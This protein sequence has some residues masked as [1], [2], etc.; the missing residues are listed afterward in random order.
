GSGAFLVSA[1]RYLAS[2]AE[3]ALVRDGDWH[4][5]DVT[6][7]DRIT[8]RRDVGQRCLFGADL[9]PMAVQLGRLSLWLAT[10]SGERPLTFLDHHLVSGDSLV[11]AALNDVS[12]QPPGRRRGV[13]RSALPLFP[14]AGIDE[15]LQDVVAP[16]EQ[17]AAERDGRG[18]VVRRKETLLAALHTDGGGLS[19]WKAVLGLWCACWFWDEG[20]PP[21][22]AL[23]RE[24]ADALLGGKPTLP[25]EASRPWLERA[26]A[27]ARERRFL[28]WTLEFPEVFYDSAGRRQLDA[29]FDAVLGNP[30]WDMVRRDRGSA[31]ERA[32]RRADAQQLVEFAHGSGVYEAEAH[33]HV[34][35]YQLFVE[36]ALQLTRPGAR[37]GLVLPSGLASDAGSAPLRRHLFERAGVDSI[38]GLDNRAGVFPIHRSVRFVVV[39]APTRCRPQRIACR[40]RR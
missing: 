27:I 32:G 29:G 14:D 9:N 1:C 5:G 30:P 38:V 15:V 22:A 13:R 26:A 10:L 18:G 6:A 19:P 36:R 24:L 3:A 17:L 4:A 37:I 31:A 21:D 16:R 33:A 35:R 2:A 11:G 40:F 20:H 23:F 34:N 28:H 7:D 8:L 12:R 39:T 25:A